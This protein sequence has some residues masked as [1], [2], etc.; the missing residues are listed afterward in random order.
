MVPPRYIAN[1]TKF[2]QIIIMPNTMYSQLTIYFF[3]TEYQDVLDFNRTF[4]FLH[5]K[6]DLFFCNNLHG[7]YTDDSIM[8]EPV[9]IYRPVCHP[10]HTTHLIFFNFK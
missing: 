5:F 6:L 9:Y 7:L 1:V 2:S 3:I 4:I 8:N 10:Q